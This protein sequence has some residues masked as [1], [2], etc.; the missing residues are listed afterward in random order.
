MGVL[1]LMQMRITENIQQKILARAAFE[2]AF[3]FPK[4]KWEAIDSYYPPELSN[5]FF[6][7]LTVQKGLAKLILDYSAA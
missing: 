4:M 2:F 3:R 5:R 7:S 1:R 6:D